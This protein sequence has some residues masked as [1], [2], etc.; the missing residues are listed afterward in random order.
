MSLTL[1]VFQFNLNSGALY[2]AK[3]AKGRYTVLQAFAFSTW[4]AV[5]SAAETNFKKY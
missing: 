4:L 1:A 2:A 3:G 5:L